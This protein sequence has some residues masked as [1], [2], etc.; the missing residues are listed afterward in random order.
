MK[1]YYSILI[2]GYPYEG[3]YEAQTAKHLYDTVDYTI[4]REYNG[5]TKSL[6][7]IVNRYDKRTWHK[8]LEDE[9]NCVD[10]RRKERIRTKVGFKR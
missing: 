8:C 2:D 10:V 9:I 6:V 3:S 5:H 4:S 1:S 7:R